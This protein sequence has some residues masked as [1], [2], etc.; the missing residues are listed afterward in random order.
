PVH[1]GIAESVYR[2]W[3]DHPPREIEV[4][5]VHHGYSAGLNQEKIRRNVAILRQWIQNEPNA[6]YGR[7][8]LGMN[9]RF[10]GLASEGLYHLEQAVILADRDGDRNSLTFLEELITTCHQAFQEAGRQEKAQ[11]LRQTVGQWR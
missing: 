10:L 5:L 11:W 2:H 6:V 7:Y 4:R 8:K 1:E 3:P 9:L